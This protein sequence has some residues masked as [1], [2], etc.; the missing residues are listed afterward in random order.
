MKKNAIVPF[1][2]IMVLGI[3]LIF[4]LSLIG[5]TESE[6]AGGNGGDDPSVAM[7]P[8]EIYSSKCSQC[9]GGNYEGGAGPQLAGVGERLSPEEIRDVLVNGRG[10]MPKGLVSEANLDDMV[11]WLSNLK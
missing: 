4:A 11:E 10:A 5:N 8:E 6:R 1:V 9:H 3:G 7:A 2:L